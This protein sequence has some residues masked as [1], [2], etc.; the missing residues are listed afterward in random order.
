MPQ[1]YPKC[2]LDLTGTMFNNL[3]LFPFHTI[4]HQS[5]MMLFDRIYIE[6]DLYFEFMTKNN[7]QHRIAE[8]WKKRD[9][10]LASHWG[11]LLKISEKILEKEDNKNRLP[12]TE[13]WNLFIIGPYNEEKHIFDTNYGGPQENESIDSDSDDFPLGDSELQQIG[14]RA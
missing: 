8:E 11:F 10:Q 2:V 6:D 3:F 13:E 4:L 12:K 9:E 14:K 1:Q 7:I 5:F